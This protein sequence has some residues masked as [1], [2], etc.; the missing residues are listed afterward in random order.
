[1]QQQDWIAETGTGEM[2]CNTEAKQ[3]SLC[4]LFSSEMRSAAKGQPYRR[5]DFGLNHVAGV[6]SAYLERLGFACEHP[7]LLG[8]VRRAII[9]LW[10]KPV[11]RRCLRQRQPAC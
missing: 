9:L 8:F 7:L 10:L 4:R 11:L 3:W 2:W 6:T 5:L 1:M